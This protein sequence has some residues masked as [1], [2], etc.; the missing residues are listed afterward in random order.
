MI[1]LFKKIVEI[2]F[3]LEKG[4]LIRIKEGGYTLIRRLSE[5][6]RERKVL[7][8]WKRKERV[9][10]K[11]FHVSVRNKLFREKNQEPR[12]KS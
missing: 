12:R 1:L 3:I 5:E 11:H 2:I 7:V 9:R 6:L 8:L 4:E 10:Q